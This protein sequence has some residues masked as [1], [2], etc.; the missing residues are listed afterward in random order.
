MTET[1]L[2]AFHRGRFWLVQPAKGAHR[3]GMDAMILAAAVRD[4]FSGA[5]ADFGAGAGAAGLAVAVRCP[6]AT[7]TLVENAPEMAAFARATLAHADNASLA[8]R[9]SLV[10][11]DVTL[12]GSRR[13]AA[14]LADNTFDFIIM[15]PPF[16]KPSDRATPN[17]L[18]QMAH[19]MPEG[20]FESWV[21]SAAALVKPRG[22]FAAIIRPE[23][24]PELL[25]P[26]SRRFGSARIKP[27]HPRPDEP[28]IRLIVCATRGSR[29]QL[30]MEPPLVLHD[31][32]SNR[33][34]AKADAL[35]N[36]NAA[37]FAD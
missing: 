31:D 33:F 32:G 22:G 16:N 5:L 3:A 7:V 37:L 13:A 1:T 9:V 6:G 27:I 28:A 23:N 36:G 4:G 10:E 20:M 30:S 26:L 35:I 8:P 25:A 18:K 2:D 24:L 12:T 34:S 15:N 14:G 17:A 21:R 11:A 19:V 29:G